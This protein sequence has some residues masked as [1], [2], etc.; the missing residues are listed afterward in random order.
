MIAARVATR[1]LMYKGIR[2]RVAQGMQTAI[3]NHNADNPGAIALYH[4]PRFRMHCT[5][6]DY[7][8]RTLP[9]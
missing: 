9:A 7:R 8:K 4:S 3:V 1:A 2:R 5:I 6:S